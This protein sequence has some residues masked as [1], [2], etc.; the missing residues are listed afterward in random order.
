MKNLAMSTNRWTL[1]VIGIVLLLAGTGVLTIAFGFGERLMPGLSP[2][3]TPRSFVDVLSRAGSAV[4]GLLLAVIVL[5]AGIAWLW[6][7]VPRKDQAKPFRLQIDPRTGL[8]TLSSNVIAEAV[9]DDIDLT[10]GAVGAHVIVRGTA[11]HPELS[12]RVDVEEQADINAV[13]D[14]IATRVTE[15]CSQALGVPLAAVAIEVGISR[16]RKRAQRKIRMTS[17]DISARRVAMSQ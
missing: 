9:A 10:P 6:S 17:A 13:V 15:H 3:G 2:D 14:D 8:S 4:I 7:Q 11:K 16:D 12:I 5:I 1:A